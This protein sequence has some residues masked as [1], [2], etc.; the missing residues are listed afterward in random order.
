MKL[1]T[2]VAI[3]ILIRF[4]LS[5]LWSVVECGQNKGHCHGQFDEQRL[6]FFICWA[7]GS[8]VF[9]YVQQSLGL[10]SLVD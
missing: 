9:V 1:D 5:V 3:V 2:I 8:C 10:K 6:Q 4:A 7:Q